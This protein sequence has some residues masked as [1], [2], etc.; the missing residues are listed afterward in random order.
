[1]AEN[2]MFIAENTL[3]LLQLLVSE[4]LFTTREALK[5]FENRYLVI[6]RI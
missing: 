4:G 5:A 6:I 3:T 2:F 1:M